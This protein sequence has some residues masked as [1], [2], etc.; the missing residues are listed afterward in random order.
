MREPP[1]HDG[2]A[3]SLGSPVGRGVA[4]TLGL[5][6]VAFVV[7]AACNRVELRKEFYFDEAWR[8][9]IIRSAHPFA[10]IRAAKAPIPPLWPLILHVT[11]RFVP[12]RF[13]SL[14][15][16]NLALSALFPASAGQFVRLIGFGS[17]DSTQRRARRIA[18]GVG[19]TVAVS[20]SLDAYGLAT[21]LNDYSF[22]AALTFGLVVIWW[23]VDKAGLRAAWLI[24]M[25]LVLSIG[26]ISGLFLLP[27]IAVWLVQ[28]RHRRELRLAWLGL[29]GAGL[30]A[31][32][33]Y[34]GFYRR[35]ADAGLTQFWSDDILRGGHLPL[36]DTLIRAVR[37]SGMLI[38]PW[39]RIDRFGVWPGI[40]FF[41]LAIAGLY[42]ARR[43]WPW[44]TVSAVACWVIAAMASVA[45]GWPV[46][47]V[48]VN[49]PF[50]GFWMI[51]CVLAV[52]HVA[53]L[54]ARERNGLKLF[55][56]AALAFAAFHIIQ[57][58]PDGPQPYARGLNRD[59]DPIRA[60]E[61]ADVVVVAYHFMSYPY[62]H[63]GLVNRAPTSQR[64][65][66]LQ[67]EQPLTSDVYAGLQTELD[68]LALPIGAEVWCVLPYE[69]G[70]DATERA[71]QVSDHRFAEIFNQT[72]ERA[73][74]IGLRKTTN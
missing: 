17:G 21:Y 34:L 66:F 6:V 1:Q 71:C 74:V 12:G 35:S 52:F 19:T 11:S 40:A 33:V 26:T 65:H 23:R 8:S 25:M 36:I 24:P 31:S 45:G 32:G 53:G 73:H 57:T 63:D 67:E 61:A 49:L 39:S 27:V 50:L 3:P 51:G 64:Y 18:I 56:A 16:Q 42:V 14:R 22:Q 70:P 48:R 38:F 37:L 41:V 55:G 62:I 7:L 9:D 44:L 54:V 58:P 28:Q 47:A 10:Q 20:A 59:L 30:V 4:I 2:S 68:R 13:A 15:L 46:T 29:I 60:S 69:I 72:L 43:A 5:W